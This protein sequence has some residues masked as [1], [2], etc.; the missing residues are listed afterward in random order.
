[1]YIEQK[2]NK[3]TNKIK[4]LIM[5]QLNTNKIEKNPWW[6]KAMLHIIIIQIM[7]NGIYQKEF[8]ISGLAMLYM[9]WWSRNIQEDKEIVSGISKICLLVLIILNASD[10][11]RNVGQ[12]IQWM[13]LNILNTTN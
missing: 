13:I 9:A 11:Y 6:V 3:K 1:M 2:I 12:L 4:N 10:T 8:L 5:E 7:L